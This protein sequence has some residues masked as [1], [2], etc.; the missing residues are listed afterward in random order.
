MRNFAH[1]RLK[2]RARRGD[3]AQKRGTIGGK[4]LKIIYEPLVSHVFVADVAQSSLDSTD[5]QTRLQMQ[6]ATAQ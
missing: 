4:R 3:S 1:A 5:R 6:K 2:V